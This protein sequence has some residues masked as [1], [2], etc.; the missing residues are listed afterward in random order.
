M[1]DCSFH[2]VRMWIMYAEQIS[3]KTIQKW[4]NYAYYNDFNN[5]RRSYVAF[6]IN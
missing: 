4:T 5:M 6:N 1:T 3:I 2:I